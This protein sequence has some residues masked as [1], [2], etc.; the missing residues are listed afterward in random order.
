MLLVAGA[1]V[2]CDSKE[3]S[4]P[5]AENEAVT[6][7]AEIGGVEITEIDL[8]D[9]FFL[10]LEENGI[11]TRDME[12]VESVCEAWCGTFVEVDDQLIHLVEARERQQ[13][14]PTMVLLHGFGAWS[15][16]WRKNIDAWAEQYHV[17]AV[18]LPGFGFSDNSPN[19][20]YSLRGQAQWLNRFL[21]IQN[22]D[23][24]ILIGHSMGGGI[25]QHF[26]DQ[27][28]EK[29]AA[30]V[31][32]A[33]AASDD[34]TSV[35]ARNLLDLDDSQLELAAQFATTEFF[36]EQSLQSVFADQDYLSDELVMFYQAPL[37]RPGSAEALIKMYQDNLNPVSINSSPPLPPILLLQS[38]KDQLFS[39]Q[40]ARNI[41]DDLGLTGENFQL[42]ED[43]G[44]ALHEEESEIMN[45]LVLEWMS[46]L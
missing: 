36:T 11:R 21:E 1:V 30:L 23:S 3:A 4:A 33:P 2:A 32:I 17:L 12:A 35:L 46:T 38:K 45:T 18:D 20:D 40:H 43:G 8:R 7:S 5:S 41:A 14:K 6:N 10:Q 16:T 22:L 15:Y 24:V 25:A 9:K 28:P 13:N 26:M 42:L 39:D 44:H 27:F 37:L 34:G 31:L 19:N 29:L